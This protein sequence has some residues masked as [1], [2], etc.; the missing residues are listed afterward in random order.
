MNKTTKKKLKKSEKLSDELERINKFHNK[1]G[2]IP[3]N[4]IEESCTQMDNLADS[5]P[6]IKIPSNYDELIQSE[7]KRKLKGEASY[8]E[9]ELSGRLYDF[10]K[11][12]SVLN[13]PREDID[14]LEE[15]LKTNKEKTKKTIERLFNSR[16]VK[17]YEISLSADIPNV[18]RQAE[19]FTGAYVEK[20]HRILGKF[21]QGKTEIGE[22]LRDINATPSTTERSYFNSLT[23]TLAISIPR[24]CYSSEDG[25]LHIKDEELIRIYGHE[26]M[27]HALNFMVTRSGNIPSLFKKNSIVTKSTSES[28]AQFYEKILLEDLKHSPETQKKLGIEHKFQDIYQEV[29]D[30]EQIKEYSKKLFQYSISVLGDKKLGRY[31][32][33]DTMKKKRKKIEEVEISKKYSTDVIESNK[34]NFDSEGNLNAGL[35]SELIYAAQPVSRALKEFEKK[36]IYYNG[37]G[38]NIIDRTFLEGFWTPTGFVDNA[39]LKAREAYFLKENIGAN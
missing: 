34:Y 1:Y 10:D 36:G 22:F 6:E 27:G 19:E 32:D 31:D 3:C 24:I 39:R 7:L 2:A 23:N 30:T 12:I 35:V 29:E 16:D 38:R 5:I 17:N 21:L 14:S 13:I 25:I 9:Q 37:N 15:W 11:V 20:Y 18:R 8:L 33:P 26:G 28:I 4:K